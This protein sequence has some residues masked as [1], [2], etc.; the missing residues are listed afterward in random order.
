MKKLCKNKEPPGKG[1]L[2]ATCLYDFSEG[3]RG[4]FLLCQI[5]DDGAAGDNADE[6]VEIVHH[7]NKVVADDV[8]QQFVQGS[9]NA[10]RGVFLKNVPDVEPLQVLDGA[11]AGGALVG[12]EPPEEVSLADGSHV[13]ALPVD[14]GNGA[15]AV[16]PEFF[17]AL[18]HRV[19]VVKE[20]DAVF[21]DQEIRNIHDH[22]SFLK[23][24]AARLGRGGLN[25][26]IYNIQEEAGK[27]VNSL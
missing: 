21:G 11:G 9:G 8:V 1:R 19:V 2:H 5:P 20:G 3:R 18:T 6:T 15:E 13:L 22:A 17:Q 10:D 16:V 27:V 26:C 23:G 4:F 24:G 7:G 25:V 14:D 12:N